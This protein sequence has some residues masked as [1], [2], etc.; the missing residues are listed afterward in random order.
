M[1]LSMFSRFFYLTLFFSVF[2][3]IGLSGSSALA[4]PSDAKIKI[5]L[6]DIS[7]IVRESDRGQ[8]LKKKLE[9]DSKK[10]ASEVE[11]KIENFEKT[12]EKFL[13][14]KD[15]LNSTALLEKQEKLR[16][17]KASLERD[18]AD[19]R[20]SLQIKEKAGIEDIMKDTQNII[21]EVGEEENFTVI[22]EKGPSPVVL[23]GD[24]S[25]DITDEVL[26]RL[27]DL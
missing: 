13:K 4:A 18:A 3:L 9:R 26:K 8:K 20:R 2:S 11:G 27:N 19:S 17:Q 25:I 24:V 15:S 12:K 10:V 7:K 6:V 16:Q 1:N 21:R 23:Y 22:L 5:G 14:Q